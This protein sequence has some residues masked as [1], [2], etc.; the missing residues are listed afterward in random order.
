[1]LYKSLQ[2]LKLLKTYFNYFLLQFYTRKLVVSKYLCPHKEFENNCISIVIAVQRLLKSDK[3][4][5]K[6]KNNIVMQEVF[7][8]VSQCQCN[9]IVLFVLQYTTIQSSCSVSQSVLK[10]T[11]PMIEMFL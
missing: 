5:N 10:K 3:L 11:Q 6:T 2:V 8:N 4:S 1:M 9:S 7:K